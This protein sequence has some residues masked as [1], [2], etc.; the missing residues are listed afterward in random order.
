MERTRRLNVWIAA[1][2]V[3]LLV[4]GR[5]P[6]QTTFASITGMVTDS[7]G[8]AVANANIVARNVATNIET[9]TTSNQLGDYK[10]AQLIEGTYSLRVTTP[11][12]K[13]FIAED[14]VLVARDERRIDVKLE[15]G[16]V[17]TS[18]EVKAGATLIETDTA[19]I[20][21]TKNAQAIETMPLNAVRNAWAFISLAPGVVTQQN[22]SSMPRYSGSEGYQSKWTVDGVSMSDGYDNSQM[23]PLSD[24]LGWMQEIRL[25]IANNS[26][27]FGG[28]GQISVISKSGT[29]D[30]HFFAYDYYISPI[31]KAANPF[32]QAHPT[33]VLHQ[34]GVGVGGPVVIPGLYNGK[35]RTFFFAA[36]EAFRGSQQFTYT[37]TVP[38]AAMQQGNFSSLLPGTV[39]KNPFTGQ[40][41]SNNVLPTSGT[42]G[43]NTITQSWG[44]RFYPLPNYGNAS[45]FAANNFRLGLGEPYISGNGVNNINVRVDHHISD[46]TSIFGR[47]T[48]AN[49]TDP[50]DLRVLPTLGDEQ[51][52]RY[53]HGVAFSYTHTFTPHLLFESRWGLALNHIE[54]QGPSSIMGPAFVQQYGLVGLAPNLPNY[55][56]MT[57]IAWSGLGLT[58]LSEPNYS[59][60]DY[61][62][63]TDDF[64]EILSWSHGRHNLKMGLNLERCEYDNLAAATALFGS[65]TFSNRFT[66]Y[67]YADF[68]LGIPTTSSIAYPPLELLGHRWQYEGFVTDDFKVNSKLTL[69]L[70]VRYELKP[71]WIEKNNRLATFDIATGKMVVPDAAL[72]E[73]SPL[74]PT[75]YLGVQGANSAG[76]PQ[77]LIRADKT[78]F[79]PRF[80]IAYRPW[81]D[82]TVF[83]SG[84][85][86][87]WNTAPI[88]PS[89]GP[90]SPYVIQP[91][92]YTNPT[93]NPIVL[94][95]VFPSS[96]TSGPSTVSVPT[97]NN[98]NLGMPYSQQYNFTI[99]H[100]R[101]DTGFRIS[102][103]GTN[104]RRDWWYY[105]YN[106]PVPNTLTYV[107][108]V[109]TIPFPNYPGINYRT[110]GALHNYNGLTLA[111]NRQ[112][113]KGLY[114]QFGYT[115]ARDIEELNS[116]GNDPDSPENPFNRRRDRGPSTD[117]PTSR[118]I[119][120][121][122]YQLPFGQGR[123]WLSGASRPVNA[124][125]GGWEFSA[126]FAFYSGMFLTPEWSGSDPVGTTYTTS[127]TPA[128]VTIRPNQIG[129]PNTGP[130]TVQDWFNLNAFA[131]PTP[132]SFGTA[133]YG[134]IKG[135][136]SNVF[137]AGV[138]K[139]IPLKERLNLRLE[140]TASNLFNHPNW[141]NPDTTITDGVSYGTIGGVGS[142]QGGSGGDQAGPRTLRAGLRLE[143]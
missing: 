8:A 55:P 12:F 96:G 95:T 99:E 114:W 18:V 112:M 105:N 133:G 136:H 46:R 122:L 5:A 116:D 125:A 85:G 43:I 111:A 39:I 129:N 77:D 15:V 57:N 82:R 1:V 19:R 120:N 40:P 21:D 49:I 117:Q 97:A 41:Y 72:T 109:S 127:S 102:Y 130:K 107:Q 132:G 81:G 44:S 75:S 90:I 6:A 128:S 54:V 48:Y 126:M 76:Y 134:V 29:N 69:Q 98:P 52:G 56:G 16:A 13:E 73:V 80:G 137:H 124:L 53:D 74:F 101:W 106:S 60:P 65:L 141:N 110:N 103:T 92:A 94:P 26:A 138:F 104:T 142:I 14:V 67:T 25:D 22:G 86:I 30:F 83:R 135:P 139:N 62:N 42:G 3:L 58:G 143:W 93:T 140:L 108:K 89:M 61:R 64:Q 84:Y 115:W 88:V 45:V 38:T 11:G 121:G 32:T 51:Y 35:N 118:V 63:H 87:F 113:A 7:S 23:S 71:S 36:F 68:L 123:H 131:A 59:I 50:T 20:A 37:A 66:G 10:V 2:A 28:L 100:Q 17:V 4:Q 34:P 78:N 91:N 31:F 27:E 9:K 47:V 119:T 24:K 70:G 33:G 79:A